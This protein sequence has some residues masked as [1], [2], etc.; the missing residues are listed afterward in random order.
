VDSHKKQ[1]D[2]VKNAISHMAVGEGAGHVT[3]ADSG[4]NTPCGRDMHQPKGSRISLSAN[5]QGFDR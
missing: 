5:Q 1:A 3:S 4:E 2:L